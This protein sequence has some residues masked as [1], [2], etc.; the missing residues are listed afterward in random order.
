MK[1]LVVCQYFHPEQFR[2]NDICFELVRRGHEVTVLTGLPNYPQG[3]VDARY[4]WFRNRRETVEGVRVIR[5]WLLGRGKGALR[6]ALNYLSFALSSAWKALFM[7]TDFDL[8]LVYQLS[9]VTMALP[10]ILMKRRARKP[11]V[12]YCHD[13]WPE[14]VASAGFHNGSALYRI[15]LRLSRWIYSRADTVFASSMMFERYFRDTLRLDVPVVHLPVYAEALF[16]EIPPKG[17]GDTLDLLFAGNV[18]EMQSVDTIIRA[19]AALKDEPGLATVRFLIV[20]DGSALERCKA[21]ASELDARNVLF[22]GQHPVEEMPRFYAR[23][24]AFL[25]TLG[26]NEAISFTLPNKVQSYLAA[27]RPILGAIDG[28]TRQVVES[29]DCGLC[30]AAEDWR[31]L[32]EVV[33]RFASDHAA[34]ARWS[35]NARECYNKNFARERYFVR[36]HEALSTVLKGGDGNH[37]HE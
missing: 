7:E 8:I 30:A 20:G 32:A 22:H 9:P 11:L 6:L 27:G 10:A 21:L 3:V 5:S 29:F 4:R 14:S 12:I 35:K 28:E 25:V 31:G 37:V 16:E 1:L 13:L 15:L 18:G 2:V 19:A 34:H 17:A 36:L 26:K 24:D 23:A 33:R